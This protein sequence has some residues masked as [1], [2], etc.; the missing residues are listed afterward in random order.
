LD[1][2]RAPQKDR[3]ADA[4]KAEAKAPRHH[5][6]V[7][8][9]PRGT[10]HE[11]EANRAAQRFGHQPAEMRPSPLGHS[12]RRAQLG[13]ELARKLVHEID[14]GGEMLPNETQAQMEGHFHRKLDKV[15][16]H[17]GNVVD[18]ITDAID[19]RAFTVGRHIFFASDAYAPGDPRF[20]RLLAHEL[21]H[22]FQQGNRTD[23]Y[24]IQRNDDDGEVSEN[25]EG[26]GSDRHFALQFTGEG[27]PLFSMKELELPKINNKVKGKSRIDGLDSIWIANNFSYTTHSEERSTQQ[28]ANW[29]T[30]ITTTKTKID[31]ALNLFPAH[32][33]SAI[34][35]DP[36]D[37]LQVKNAEQLIIGT[38]SQI[39]AAPQFLI[40]T[41]DKQGNPAF[42]DV[43]HYREH[44]LRGRDQM[45]NT[46]L[47]H[48]STNRSSG[49]RIRTNVLDSINDLF[50]RARNDGFFEGR[51]ETRDIGRITRTPRD[52]N[53]H[54]KNITTGHDFGSGID[55]WTAE[56]IVDAKHIKNGNRR[57]VTAL[58]L[59][60]MQQRG[61]VADGD[62]PVTTVLWFLH[63]DRPFYKT[64]DIADPTS[65]KHR[66]QAIVN[67]DNAL[68][69]NFKVTS[70]ALDTQAA[71][72]TL[73]SGQQIGSITGRIEGNR[74][75]Y[76]DRNL[77]E[78]VEGKSIRVGADIVLPLRFDP[79]F[80]FGGY[81]D[82][83]GVTDALRNA[84]TDYFELNG[85][86]PFSINQ[87][88]LD[89][90]WTMGFSAT[91]TASHPMFSGLEA[92]L[93]LGSDGIQLDVAIP[94]DRLDF[95]FFR[96]TEA[97][98]SVAYSEN[99]PVFGGSAAFEM[100]NIGQ[101]TVT[102]DQT[103]F[104]G[105]FNFD[106]DFVDP[107]TITVRYED[108]SWS[109]NA[110][111]G[112]V[113]GV[114]PGLTS[115]TINVG[116]DE[117]GGFSFT[118]HAFVAL[119]GQSE[120]VEIEV[121][122]TEDEGIVIAGN[123]A[124]DTSAWP[125]IENA[126]VGVRV[127]YDPATESW[128]IGG[129]GSADFALPG[130]TG[131]LHAAYQDGG[132]LFTGNGELAIGNATG[133]FDFKVGN[134][135]VTEEG[136]FDTS[137]APTE[138]FDVWGSGSV[139]ITFGP[140]L[141][142]TAGLAYTP[143][144][145]IIISGEIALPP[146]I[147]LFAQ[148]EYRR[149]ILEFPR[150]EF[151]IFGVSIPVVGSIGVFGFIGGELRGY[152]TVGPATLDDAAVDV[153]YTLGDPDSA[154][155]HGESHLNFGMEAG[156]ALDLSGGLGLGAAVADVTGEVGITAA[157]ELEIDAGAD[158]DVDWTPL[159]GLSIELDLH[160]S[161]SPSFKVGVFGRV[162]TSVA[163]YGEVWSERWDRTLAEFGSGLTI[164][165]VQ[166]ASW[167]EE[168]GLRLDFADAEFTYPR[169]D[170]EE[171]ASSIMDR[172]V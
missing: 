32:H 105:Q 123:V 80:G 31:R 69:K 103:A 86:S 19:A 88:G 115:G 48:N 45:E 125:A 70:V 36:V 132:I 18:E 113:D 135:P 27:A 21:V 56:Q 61:I 66:G 128:N 141:T 26:T 84:R 9:E 46:W 28:R 163:L 37:C 94:T 127:A 76:Y 75:T 98:L 106:F 119:P 23:D 6:P 159:S 104:E 78:R 15:R 114:I 35:S 49:T 145:E 65:P 107:A 170:I 1:R 144:D 148:R 33:E 165:V 10:S 146:S 151:P 161:A 120:P 154:V 20:Q 143:D 168:N 12:G 90:E 30:Y 89:D 13:P 138:E 11:R 167:D 62:G 92:T 47:L 77:D 73:E 140:Y 50:T 147:E 155:I 100:P 29:N 149:S 133:E 81:L 130:V 67:R 136:E 34:D 17:Q 2:A 3:Q 99:G 44:Q 57:L 25:W 164:G 55:T 102:A 51:N 116:I 97:S 158:L 122:Y 109:F 59:R 82:R 16:T 71:P 7:Y 43:D 24:V 4:A 172:I 63:P 152:A 126:R 134:Y 129:E 40:P 68:I 22:T 121:T 131:T 39:L 166:P 53:L 118:G 139:S 101:G 108:E 150:L 74:A 112:I 60:E 58:S 91:L 54:F 96:V 85:M 117:E 160:A 8:I 156:L 95:G 52:R 83:S 111:L 64:V 14:S 137:A 87:A 162:A 110:E 169:F 72:D 93:S 142:G 38:R 42:F 157:L 5:Q 124:F 171:I 79:R 153:E 41:W